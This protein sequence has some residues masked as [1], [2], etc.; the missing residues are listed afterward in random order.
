MNV[1]LKRS[2]GELELGLPDRAGAREF[3]DAARSQGGFLVTLDSELRFRESVRVTVRTEDGF[4]LSFDGEVSGVSRTG[5]GGFA[6]AFLMTQWGLALDEQL[7]AALGGL[8]SAASGPTPEPPPKLPPDPATEPAPEAERAGGGS[9][10]A[11]PKPV[12]ET[13]GASPMHRIRTMNP[14]QRT[15]LA[16]KADRVERQ[17]LLKD[18]SP[19]VLQ[20][21][22]SNPRIEGKDILR[23]VKSTH[24]AA[25]VLKRVAEDPRWGKNQ[26]IL[27]VI[28]KNPKTPS[29]QAI[30]L[31]EKLRTSDLRWMAKM[32]SGVRETIRRAALREYLRRTGR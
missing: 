20:A 27:A 14:N 17:I 13:R 22:L 11:A 10:P 30:R 15:M 31:V 7:G 29:P 9:P 26:E 21:L 19:Q 2:C 3:F 23:I 5:A 4:E 8:R 1:T 28:A 16:R 6:T 32:S 25:P 18:T 12:G 24:T